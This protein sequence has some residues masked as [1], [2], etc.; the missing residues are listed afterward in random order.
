MKCPFALKLFPTAGFCLAL[1]A[2]VFPSGAAPHASPDIKKPL[3]IIVNVANPVQSLSVAQLRKIFRA[4]QNHWPD[5]HHIT[6]ALPEPGQPERE[7]VLREIYQ[8]S[9]RDFSRYF[10]QATFTGE[11]LSVP[12]TLATASGLRKF[13]FN[14]PGAIACVA[15]DEVD[16]TVK[17]VRLDGNLPGEAGYRLRLGAPQTR[18]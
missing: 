15:A 5:G 10:V 9:E 13:I 17:V 11:A 8:M 4:E 1:L 6:I 7:V 3:A 12:K 18:P 2:G 16:A 14:V